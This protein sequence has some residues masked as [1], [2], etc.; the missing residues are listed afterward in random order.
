MTKLLA[1][2]LDLVFEELVLRTHRDVLAYGHA[3]APRHETS[4]A[5][6]D[7]GMGVT[8]RRTGDAHDQAHVGHEAVGRS[9]HGLAQDA[10][11]AR[12]VGICRGCE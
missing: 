3:E 9:K 10:L 12:L 5:G 2:K 6:Q 1:L 4:D 8:G 7:D 11:A